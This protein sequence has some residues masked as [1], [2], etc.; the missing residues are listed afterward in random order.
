VNY[1]LWGARPAWRVLKIKRAPERGASSL[2][3]LSLLRNPR[4]F[5]GYRHLPICTS[6]SRIGI[7]VS[8]PR[9]VLGRLNL[10]C[11]LSTRHEDPRSIH[12]Q[13][14]SSQWAGSGPTLLQPPR[15]SLQRTRSINTSLELARL[16]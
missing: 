11:T 6:Q 13:T 7:P 15:L 9:A 12:H 3:N 5:S 2:P 10:Y 14:Y 1:R 16:L 4:L 8:N